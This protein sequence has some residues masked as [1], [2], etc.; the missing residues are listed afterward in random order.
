MAWN[1]GEDDGGARGADAAML[2]RV[3]VGA[4][5]KRERLCLMWQLHFDAGGGCCNCFDERRMP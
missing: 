1:S 4:G 5:R 3:A 2:E